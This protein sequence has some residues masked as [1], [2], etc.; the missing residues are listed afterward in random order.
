METLTDY[1]DKAIKAYSLAD[2]PAA[3]KILEDVFGPDHFRKS[4]KARITS[5]ETICVEKGLQTEFAKRLSAFEK[6]EMM[7]DTL[8]EGWKP[9]YADS[10]EQKWF[11][12]F[13][14]KPGSGWLLYDYGHERTFARVGARLVFKSRDLAEHAVKHF[15][16]EY[17]DFLTKK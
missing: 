7:V 16:D 17:I 13:E 14:Y 8:N 12:I 5:M 10:S 6:L 3:R 1:K 9:N 2:N 15:M 4:I 11:P